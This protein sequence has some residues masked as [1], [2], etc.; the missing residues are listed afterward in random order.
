MSCQLP[1]IQKA[2]EHAPQM[3]RMK[4]LATGLAS[5]YA[6]IAANVLYSLGSVP[7]PLSLS[8]EGRIRALGARHADRR[9][10]LVVRPWD[11]CLGR[12]PSER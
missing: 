8:V 5:G 2:D 3:S 1:D 12:T 11:E 7:L 9:L 6:A 10:S 4:N